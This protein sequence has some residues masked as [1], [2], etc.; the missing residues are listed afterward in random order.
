MTLT[1]EE[2]REIAGHYIGGIID[3]AKLR[4][5][6]DEDGVSPSLMGDIK[7]DLSNAFTGD[8]VFVVTSAGGRVHVVGKRHVVD[9]DGRLERDTHGKAVLL[10][11][12]ASVPTGHWIERAYRAGGDNA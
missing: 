4:D 6:T 5:R 3:V 2:A 1:I 8:G 9:R 11:L 12:V 7:P 10:P